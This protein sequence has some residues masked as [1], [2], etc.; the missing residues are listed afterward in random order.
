[1]NFH[2][3]VS[4]EII[5]NNIQDWYLKYFLYLTTCEQ[6]WIFIQVNI[7]MEAILKITYNYHKNFHEYH[8]VFVGNNNK[9]NNFQFYSL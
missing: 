9:I 6:H 7:L 1:M 8:E 4:W 2:T 5:L 3:K